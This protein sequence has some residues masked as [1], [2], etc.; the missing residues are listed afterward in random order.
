VCDIIGCCGFAEKVLRLAF[1]MVTHSTRLGPWT[2]HKNCPCPEKYKA[3]WQRGSVPR[4]QCIWTFNY[5]N[6]LYLILNVK[7]DFHGRGQAISVTWLPGPKQSRQIPHQAKTFVLSVNSNLNG[8][9]PFQLKAKNVIKHEFSR[10][11]VIWKS[12]A[13]YTVKTRFSSS[14]RGSSA[15][16][17][18]SWS[19]DADFLFSSSP[20]VFYGAR[21]RN[22]VH[23]NILIGLLYFCSDNDLGL[24]SRLTPRV[25]NDL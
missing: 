14:Q 23:I 19:R 6:D 2:R 13:E 21:D 22:T 10:L 7:E 4:S 5:K 11:R 8:I 25:L 15:L 16:F 17:W 12:P 1:S 9:M 3:P 20:K 18:S 24:S